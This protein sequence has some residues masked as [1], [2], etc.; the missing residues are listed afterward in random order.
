MT[1]VF[2]CPK[3]GRQKLLGDKE[4]EIYKTIQA[5]G[6]EPLC[7]DCEKAKD[8]PTIPELREMIKNTY[9]DEKIKEVLRGMLNHIEIQLCT[10]M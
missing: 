8:L 10:K 2:R 7:P 1:M 3:C 9:M 4:C 5:A 6:D